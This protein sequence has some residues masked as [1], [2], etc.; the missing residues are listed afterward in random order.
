MADFTPESRQGPKNTHA[1]D[2]LV[3]G[4]E[5]GKLVRSM[6]WSKTPLG[7][8][9]A[10]P[11]SLRTTVSLCLASNFPISLAWGPQ[12]VQIYNDGY[13]P[14]CGGKHPD[15]MG[16]DFSECWAAP[17]PVI[18]EAFERALAGETSYLENQRMFLDRNGYLEETFF[19]FSFSPIR[20][21]TGGVGGL[22][23]PVTETTA[24]MVGERRT[25]VLRDLAARSSQAQT[26]EE[27][28]SLAAQTLSDF[29]LDI[30]FALFYLLDAAGKHA[31]L[32][33]SS[34]AAPRSIAVPS[35][36]LDA[37]QTSLWPLG[38]IAHT[39]RAI[40]VENLEARFGVFS[41]H[42]YPETPKIALAL[43]ITAPG[44]DRPTAIFVAGVSTRLPLNDT[45]RAFYDL[46]AAAITS[47]VANARAYEEERKRAEALA[48]IDRAKTAFFSNVSHEFRTPLTLMLGP[49]EDELAERSEPLPAARRNTLRL[50]KLVNTLLDF[51]RIE[52][53]RM[54]ASYEPINLSVYTTELASVFRSAI[55]KGG[56][57]LTVD[58][59]PLPELI[60]VDKD[61]WEKIVLNLLSNAFKHTFEGSIHVALRW[62][63][64]HVEL[65]VTDSGVGIAQGELPHLFD[66]FHRVKGSKSRTHEGT[67]IGLALVRELIHAHGGTVQVESHEGRGSAFTVVLKT[68]RAHLPVD[69]LGA[70]G[71]QNP[72]AT[73]AMAFV[74]EASHWMAE[75]PG[76]SVPPCQSIDT[77]DD[78]NPFEGAETAN[79]PRL[80]I[81]WADDNADMR[82]YVGR[83]LAERYEVTAVA[84]GTAALKAALAAPPDLILTDVMMPGLDGFALL[85]EL[86]A[87][88]RTH[89]IP[90]ILLSARAGEESAVEGLQAGADDY[91]VKPFSAR[92]LLTRIQTHLELSMLRRKWATELELRVQERTAELEHTQQKLKKQ[93]QRL[94]L[95]HHI[96]RAT[97]E[98]QDLRSIFQ[99]VIRTLEDELHV[100]LSCICLYDP[101][102]KAFTVSNIGVHSKLLAAELGVAEQSRFGIDQNGLSPCL[103]GQLMYEP[104]IG[105]TGF[106]FLR[107]LARGGLRAMVAAPLRIESS[108][109]GILIV[110]R[111]RPQSFSSGECE[112]LQQL[113]EH[114]ALAAHQAQ[115]HGELQLAYDHLH[116]TQQAMMQQERLRA[117][118][119][120]ASGIAHDIN[121]AITPVA[122]YTESLLEQEP[123]LSQRTRTYLGIIQRAIGDVA[124]TIARMRE[125]YRQ[126]ESQITL[127]PI[128]LNTVI[129]HVLELT[130]ARWGD[131]PQ[132]RGK[133]IEMCAELATDLPLVVGIESE[134]RDSLVN[135][136]FNSVD[137]MHNGGTLTLRT[138]VIRDRPGSASQRVVVEVSDS[139]AGMD[140]ETRRRC[141]E[142]FFTTKGE[143][144]TGLGL[145]MVY[146]MAQRH[147]AE[148]TIDSALGHGTTVRLSFELPTVTDGAILP[149][150]ATPTTA[151]SGLRVL[152]IDDDPLLLSALC[153]IMESDGHLVVTAASGEIGINAFQNAYRGHEP[154]AV[155]ITDLGMPHIDGR[156]VASAVKAT[157][158]STPVILL[159]GWGQRFAIEGEISPQV[160]RVLGKPPKLAQLREALAQCCPPVRS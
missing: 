102:D 140:E 87:D 33:A 141:L 78:P 81:L 155:V 26:V 66:R 159:T 28:L 50:L 52:A 91:L 43:P 46:A 49:L 121:N 104:D 51:S 10:W 7:P 153:S 156:G 41:C 31:S 115:L 103:T 68:G 62:R 101:T 17:W 34:A 126:R 63:D 146:G 14:I 124:E 25:R 71:M 97:G 65:T 23:H 154:F 74:E 90:V 111:N 85:R 12:H 136:I 3:G 58:C 92:E 119:Q 1:E 132:Q 89:T 105:K 139:G 29:E 40:Q 94:Q 79:A 150:P 123:N 100:D 6:D 44:S 144:G 18:G 108:I 147:R 35:A 134:I 114:V 36:T 160:D 27:A 69:R 42:P 2:W 133:V 86:R 30:P 127:L 110:A 117:L 19:T 99:V 48:E 75:I 88:E 138:H 107:H 60:Y 16:Q 83:L 56:L 55:E 82:N 96:A 80:R 130:K 131:M 38:E 98:R 95:L 22:F 59:M 77:A 72:T 93:L 9:E 128:E 118:G 57:T 21:E 61:M 148:V 106:P 149:R 47:A 73:Q 13:W 122:L 67:G 39:N 152:V 109:S 116:Q 4:G 37:T 125:F 113:S 76:G 70:P 120:M 84:D 15:S 53:G 135:L 5:M 157:S 54:Q 45:Y 32:I 64:D 151:P 158:P 145:A 129:Q 11:Q 112:F 143:R 137:A 20:D 8:I 24:K 142:P